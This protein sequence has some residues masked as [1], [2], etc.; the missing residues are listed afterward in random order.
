MVKMTGRKALFESLKLQGVEYIFGNP[1]TSESP[2]M[3][4]LQFHPEFK[5]VLVFQEGVA[6][7]M[8]DAYSRATGKPAFVNLH[9]ETGLGNAVSLMH[10]AKEGGSQIVL[11]AGNLDVREYDRGRT[12]L[13]EMVE[14]F[15]KFSGEASHPDQVFG[16]INRAFHESATPPTGPAFVSF[17]A[18]SLDDIGNY[19]F[20]P[21]SPLTYENRASTKTITNAISALKNAKNPV[22]IVGDRISQSL[23]W[24]EI[25]E[26]SNISGAAVYASSYS[27]MNFPNDHPNYKGEIRLG[28]PEG[29]NIMRQHDVVIG[30]GKLATGYWMFSNPSPSF[31]EPKTTFIHIDV[32]SANLGSY[33]K[34]DIPILSDPKTALEEIT[35]GL[36]DSIDGEYKESVSIRSKQYSIDKTKVKDDWNSRVAQKYNINPI[37]AERLM[38]DAASVIPANSIIVNDAVTSGNS[39]M[40]SFTFNKPGS[41]YGGRGGALGWGMGGALGV[42]LANPDKK[43][44]AF[45]GDG[46]ALMTIQGLLTAA[47]DNIPITYVVCNNSIYRVLKV[48]MNFYRE[49]ILKLKDDNEQYLGMEFGNRI[50]IHTIAKGMNV[51]SW[52]IDDPK[53]IKPILSEAINSNK[54][55]LLDVTIDGTL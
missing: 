10:N 42:Q 31:F 37:S 27:E 11:S 43:V 44:I 12:D 55:S 41:I 15:T 8:A 53:D 25:V 26:L 45:C 52:R 20:F 21:P 18:N 9:I 33:L 3:H 48:N 24:K 51:E 54:P 28:Y 17:S 14:Q 34:T 23:A 50:D 36:S 6:I 32:D 30:I 2:I 39:L 16:L 4:E 47:K 1:G 13:V 29:K 7:G 46:S 38:S 22:F 35:N 19:E 5:Y 40:N 49:N